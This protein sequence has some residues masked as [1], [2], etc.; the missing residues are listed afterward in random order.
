MTLIQ[1]FIEKTQSSPLHVAVVGD[2]MIDEYYDVSATRMSP[3]FPIPVMLST[4][5]EPTEVAPG[6][7][8]NVAYQFKNWNSHSTLFSWL[9][10]IAMATLNSFIFT[11]GCTLLESFGNNI[12]RKRRLYDGIHPT[13][14]WDIELLRAGLSIS[15]LAYNQEKLSASFLRSAMESP[16]FDVI[17][18]S[19]YN[20]GTFY[21]DGKKHWMSYKSATI[22]DPKVGPASMWSGCTIFK[23]NSEEAEKL[24]G[25]KDWKAQ[26]QYFLD[27]IGCEH[28]VITQGGRGVVGASRS[29]KGS[30]PKRFEYHP[31]EVLDPKS[32][33]GAGDCFMAFLAM[34]YGHKFKIEE[35]VE[36]AFKAGASY[37]KNNR[38]KPITPYDL[39]AAEDPIAAKFLTPPIDREFKLVF[40]N[41]CFDL[42][43]PGH[44]S[45]LKDA[46]QYGDRLAVGVNSDES[47]KRL[48]G[49]DR[50]YIKCEDRMKMLAALECVDY[51]LKFEDD[52]PFALVDL[53]KPDVIAKGG[54]YYNKHVVGSNVAKQIVFTKMIEGYSTTNLVK[55]I[56]ETIASEP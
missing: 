38:N 4:S 18:L 15:G 6:G 39:L 32:V 40:T 55:K 31:K 48:K 52:S 24:S 34:S 16:G 53:L 33:I 41:G 46:R 21:G 54:Q 27:T 49:D 1:R 51:V 44:I 43:H 28:V 10:E 14:R 20:K 3:E 8:A 2:S 50:P 19:D 12:P 11:Q 7:A 22:V 23:P 26:S 30:Q 13:F 47:V 5:N 42:L 25:L 17:V 29:T 35:C 9:D 56:R 45:S 37:V 36:I